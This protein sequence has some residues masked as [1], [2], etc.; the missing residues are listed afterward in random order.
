MPS[1]VKL[2]KIALD[3]LD[4]SANLLWIVEDSIKLR[5]RIP[6]VAT[7]TGLPSHFKPENL[8]SLSVEQ[9]RDGWAGLLLFDEVPQGAPNALGTPDA[10][11]FSS[12]DAAF[13]MGAEIACLVL[14]GSRELPFF[15]AGNDLI[16]ATYG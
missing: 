4:F 9:T 16:V 8:V 10:H 11:P 12:P 7:D 2:H 1:N 13:L 3:E 6:E 15:R 5:G 14:T